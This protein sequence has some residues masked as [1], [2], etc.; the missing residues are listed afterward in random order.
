M[1]LKIHQQGGA[2][3]YTPFIPEL[4]SGTNSKGSTGS[5]G[6]GSGSS[7]DAKLDPLDKELLGMMKD[8]NLLPSDIQMIYDRLISFQRSTQ[9]LTAQNIGGTGSYRSVMPGM[10]QIMNLVSQAKYSKQADDAVVKQMMQENAGNELALDGYGR[11]YVQ[12]SEG[13]VEKVRISDFDSEKHLPLSNSQL[14]YLREKDPNLAFDNSIL[15]DMRNMVGISSVSKEIERIIKAFGTNESEG[16][17]SKEGAQALLDMNSPEGIYKYKQK[18]PSKG[19]KEVQNAIWDQ[20][21]TNMQHLLEARAAITGDGDPKRYILDIAMRNVSTERSIDYDTTASKAAG[22][23]TDPNKTKE[24]KEQLT[25]NNYLMQIGTRRL[26]RTQAMI[27]PTAA[28]ITDTAT[29]V[30][31]VY[32]AGMPVDHSMKGLGMM[33]LSNFRTQAEAA[34]AGDFSS[35][36]FGNKMLTPEEYDR[37]VYDGSSELNIAM[38]PFTTDKTTGQLKPDFDLFAAFNKI[39]ISQTELAQIA[40][41]SGYTLEQLGYNPKTNSAKLTNTMPFLTFSA[42]AGQDAVDIPKSTKPFLEKLSW[43]Q[44]DNIRKTYDMLVKYGTINPSK[45]DR[46]LN[47]SDS[48]RWDFYR[49]NVYIPMT[50]AARALLLSGIGEYM[51]KSE[52]TDYAARVTAREAEALAVQMAQSDPNYN[53]ISK[54]AQFN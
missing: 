19:L 28:K 26:Y 15:E 12:N 16:Y 3:I 5:G 44:G 2:L 13:N 40:R 30:A 14:L 49:G 38:L 54:L 45:N 51:P 35:V 24:E 46:K 8:Q 41:E 21:P 47:N 50:N 11:L 39:N 34:K 37:I 9:R 23:D 18:G 22:Y 42:Y 48:E 4:W 31:P 52:M 36:T 17:L 6:I 32:N 1:K 7:E 43:H 53:D 29:L 33:T 20:L 25:Q 27:V 10:L